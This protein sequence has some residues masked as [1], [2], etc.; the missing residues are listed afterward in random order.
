MGKERKVNGE[1]IGRKG[2][3]GRG[4]G[5]RKEGEKKRERGIEVEG[6]VTG[7]EKIERN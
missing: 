7:G 6:E 5:K 2:I 4:N 1:D 3:R